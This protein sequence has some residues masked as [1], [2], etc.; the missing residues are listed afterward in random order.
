M[1][2]LVLL[3]SLRE[4]EGLSHIAS[5]QS[6]VKPAS[7]SHR[8]RSVHCSEG[9][10]TRRLGFSEIEVSEMALGTQRWGSTDFNAPDKAACHALLDVATERGVNLVDTA[11]QYPIPSGRNKPEGSTEA[12]IGADRLL[13]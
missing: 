6:L 5:R 13:P 10:R 11:E 1:R 12:I 4:S 2:A 3:V 8:T 9:L 7:A